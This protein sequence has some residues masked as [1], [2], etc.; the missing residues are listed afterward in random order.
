MLGCIS[1]VR[2]HSLADK[3]GIQAG[4]KLCSVNGC[5]VRDI[6]DL[7]FLTT[8]DLV[9]LE[10]ENHDG[11]KRLLQ[12]AKYPDEDL[13]LEFESAVFD[14][15]RTCYNNCIFCF[16]DQMIPGMRP[17]LYVRDDDYRLSFLYGNFITITNMNDADFDR[18]IKT[19]L[20]PLYISVHATDPQ[21][22][23]Q[24]MHNRFA[25]EIMDKMQRL[26]DAGIQ[27]HT[28]I[29]CCPGYNDGAVLQKTFEDLYALHPGIL[30]MAVVPVG[31]TKHRA[32][33][34][35]MRTFTPDE[36]A[37]VVENVTAWQQQ[38]RE[39]TGKSFVYL[40]DE[41]YLLA[42]KELPPSDYYDG[43]PQ[44]ENGIGLTRNFLN[45]WE[46][47][48]Q[49]LQYAQGTEPA[50]IPVGES[51]YKVLQPLLDAFNAQYKTEHRFLSVKNKFFGGHV[52]VTGLLTG[53]DILPEVKNCQRVILPAVVLN[54]DN[55]FLDDMALAQ[56]KKDLNGKVEIAANAGELLHLLTVPK[57][58]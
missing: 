35:P 41:F 57:E 42:S 44:L 14:K 27:I 3:A 8:D 36:A 10:I 16:V 38:C 29:V 40:G 48:L 23:C 52:N 24:M 4:E 58:G 50:V 53:S 7:S 30:T 6:I 54:Q 18:I 28:Q 2:K 11:Q 45:E 5:A 25:G 43:F 34:H 1:K 33:L 55:L 39:E 56:F 51:A 9:E 17:S 15:V 26:L 19:H 20:S 31:L 21:V 13:G 12:I 22:R 37:Q 46:Q 49:H 32:H 47:A